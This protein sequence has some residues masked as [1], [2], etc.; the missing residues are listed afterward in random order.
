MEKREG[1]ST[2][3]ET[4]NPTKPSPLSSESYGRQQ[5]YSISLWVPKIL[6]ALLENEWLWRIGGIKFICHP[7][8]ATGVSS[9]YPYTS[10]SQTSCQRE[11]A[12]LVCNHGRQGPIEDDG[13]E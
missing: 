9:A 3:S 8:A 5:Y 7:E 2:A 4:Q 13:Q 12:G 6:L 1:V 11:R 10:T